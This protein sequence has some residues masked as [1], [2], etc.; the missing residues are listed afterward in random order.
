MARRITIL[1]SEEAE[2]RSWADSAPTE[3]LEC[4][5]G[6]HVFP[7]ITD[8]RTKHRAK[9][10]RV[11]IEAHCLRNCGTFLRKYLGATGI[12][13]GAYTRYDQDSDYKLPPGLTETSNNRLSKAQIGYIRMVLIKR[14]EKMA[15]RQERASA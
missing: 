10:G 8:E 4:R 6:R 5:V 1:T 2:F 7:G 3:V 15:A 13:E 12:L 9:Q 14:K 11:I